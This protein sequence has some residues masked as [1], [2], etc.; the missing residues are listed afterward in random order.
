[1]RHMMKYTS[2]KSLFEHLLAHPNNVRNH[3]ILADIFF[4]ITTAF[5]E[6][7]KTWSKMENKTPSYKDNGQPSE[8][9]AQ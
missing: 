9:C 7:D 8:W 5:P 1:M 6:S 3:C 4:V 2:E